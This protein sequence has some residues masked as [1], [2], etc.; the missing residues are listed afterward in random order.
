MHACTQSWYRKKAKITYTAQSPVHG[1]TQSA[2]HSAPWQTYSFHQ[3]LNM[4]ACTCLTTTDL[5][6]CVVWSAAMPCDM[7]CVVSSSLSTSLCKSSPTSVLASHSPC[8][9]PATV[10]SLATINNIS[11]SLVCHYMINTYIKK[12]PYTFSCEYFL[13]PNN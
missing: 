13:L 9:C 3:Q 1:A 8:S 7:V 10:L 2:L 12:G 6:S 4:Y 11:F 5:S